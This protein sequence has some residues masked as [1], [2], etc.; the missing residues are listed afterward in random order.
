[1]R[2]VLYGTGCILLGLF[3]LGTGIYPAIRNAREGTKTLDGEVIGYDY[4]NRT[5]L[6]KYRADNGETYEIGYPHLQSFATGVFPK[7]GLKVGITVRKDDPA[8]VTNILLLQ[9]FKRI[10]GTGYLSSSRFRMALR[11]ALLS[12]FFL[13]CGILFLTGAMH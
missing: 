3:F 13:F 6:L 4:E 9:G 12:G 8:R 2:S 7:T 1:M 5:I 10:S 11:T